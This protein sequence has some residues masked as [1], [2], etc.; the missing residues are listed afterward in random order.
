MTQTSHDIEKSKLT[1]SVNVNLNLSQT[2]ALEQLGNNPNLVIKPL[3][4]GRTVVLMNGL[5][6]RNMCWDILKDR[7][8]YKPITEEV[9]GKYKKEFDDLVLQAYLEGTITQDI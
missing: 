5:Q 8:W 1:R 3:D 9:V 4:K 6:Y 7:Q 2:D